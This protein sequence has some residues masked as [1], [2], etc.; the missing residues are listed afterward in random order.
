MGR[1]GPSVGANPDDQVWSDFNAWIAAK[2]GLLT[3]RQW[4][5]G[6][7]PA[8]PYMVTNLMGSQPVRKWMQDLFGEE[9]AESGR[10]L[11]TP[12]IEMEWHF[13]VHAYG[14][15][16][17]GFLRPLYAAAQLTQ[18]EEP[19]FPALVIHQCSQIRNLS[20]W[21]NHDWE[22]RAQMDIDLRGLTADG[23]LIDTIE[24]TEGIKII[25]L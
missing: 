10:I 3:I 19:D 15:A 4:A 22:P 20:E 17:T 13:S 23:H 16:P 6:D 9:D 2:T 11:A 18:V 12:V 7:E 5:G 8:L 21:R 24:T 25:R 14:E 1:L